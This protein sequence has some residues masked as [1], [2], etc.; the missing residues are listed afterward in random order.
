MANN[1]QIS[2]RTINP[3]TQEVQ[4]HTSIKNQEKKYTKMSHNQELKTSNKERKSLCQK[5]ETPLYRQ[6]KENED[7]NGPLSKNKTNKKTVE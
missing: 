1:F 4:Y 5:K 6:N 2:L 3:Q 7:D